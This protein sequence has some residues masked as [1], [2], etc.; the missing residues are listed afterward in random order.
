MANQ[1]SKRSENEP[2]I[3]H[4]NVQNLPPQHQTQIIPALPILFTGPRVLT[5]DSGFGVNVKSR[6]RSLEK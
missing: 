6:A 3:I 4:N 5:A 2:V 1:W